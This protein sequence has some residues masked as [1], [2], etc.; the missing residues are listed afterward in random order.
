M[1]DTYMGFS[2]A[3]AAEAGPHDERPLL[4]SGLDIVLTISRSDQPQ[5]FHLIC[6]HDSVLVTMA[7][8]GRVAFAGSAVRHFDYETGDVVYVPA[9]TPHRIV[10]TSE[11]I[12]H[13]FKL[14]ESD[15]EGVAFCCERCGREMHRLLWSLADELPQ[16]G[17]LR[18]CA[19]FNAD[20]ARRTCA[21]CQAV[22]PQV[23]LGPYRW[24]EIAR[25]ARAA[26]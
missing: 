11:S 16:E 13:R 5:P 2:Y 12:H 23:D 14:P 15:A 19:E 18:G 25:S 7:G 10:P 22:H 4:P 17:Y 21:A 26:S 3:L 1:A 8:K 24:S 6:Q 9:G 20:P